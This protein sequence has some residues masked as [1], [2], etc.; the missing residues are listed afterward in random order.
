[1]PDRR[2]LDPIMLAYVGAHL[3]GM[4]NA[5]PSTRMLVARHAGS[6]HLALWHDGATPDEHGGY[7][8]RYGYRIADATV[9]GALPHD[10]RDIHSGVGADVDTTAGMTSLVAFL[11]AAAEAYRY[12]MSNPLSAPENL[13]LFPAWVTEAA[14]LNSDELTTLAL[15]LEHPD[16]LG[17]NEPATADPSPITSSDPEP[18][19]ER[20]AWPPG[21]YYSVVFLQDT[22][23]H[24][25]VDLLQE[26][27]TQAAI[28]H[29]AQWD[30]GSETLEAALFNQDY[31]ADVP[32]YSGTREASDGPYVLSFQP[33][34]GTVHLL[35]EFPAQAPDGWPNRYTGV[36]DPAPGAAV[37]RTDVRQATAP[38]TAARH[39]IHPEPPRTRP[40][41]GLSL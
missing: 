7:R 36:S 16:G 10:G 29:L 13:N 39:V 28:D 8:Q 1:M 18:I 35:R 40:D 15:E 27:G 31:H 32:R 12:Q 38:R 24:A 14:Y 33:G 22:E 26:Q 21:R 9:P 3:S 19:D 20:P 34:L 37:A 6:L 41:D 2:Q 11:S 5:S 17:P 4:S 25:V 30:Y 23:G